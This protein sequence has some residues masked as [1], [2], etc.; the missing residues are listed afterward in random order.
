MTADAIRVPTVLSI[1]EAQQI[2]DHANG[3]VICREHGAIRD[4]WKVLADKVGNALLCATLDAQETPLAK[5][6]GITPT[7]R[8]LTQKMRD[9]LCVIG[10]PNW[11]GLHGKWWPGCGVGMGP[12]S[13]ADKK[14]AQLVARG[15]IRETQPVGRAVSVWEITR[16]G[17]IEVDRLREERKAKNKRSK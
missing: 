16:L 11:C 14:L 12:P 15:M 2:R 7:R 9:T 3:M 13:E 17:Q 1:W 8:P 10:D 5:A 4:C 6:A